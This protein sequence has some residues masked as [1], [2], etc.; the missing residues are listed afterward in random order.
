MT[1]GYTVKREGVINKGLLLG[2]LFI[3]YGWVALAQTTTFSGIGNWSD[4]A[5]WDNGVPDISYDVIIASGA[6]CTLD[7][8]AFAR[9]LSFAP[10]SI[11]STITISGT[12]TLTIESELA[13]SA[14]SGSAD[15]VLAV[16]DGALIVGSVFMPNSGSNNRNLMLTVNDGSV[17]V[18]GDV[19]MQGSSSRNYITFT[20]AGEMNVNGDFGKSDL[21]RLTGSNG[22]IR[23][24]GDFFVQTFTTNNSTIEF[25]GNGSQ[26]IRG[27]DYFNLTING[28][29]EKYLSAHSRILANL[30]LQNGLLDLA[31]RTLRIDNTASITGVFSHTSMIDFSNGGRLHK[32]G[33]N[34]SHWSGTYPIGTGTSYSPLVITS[35]SATNTN[36]Y[37]E[38]F[39]QRH[40]LLN[41]NDNA[42]ERYWLLTPP[43]AALTISGYFRYS[44]T[45]VEPPID[46]AKLIKVG[47]LNADGWQ[48]NEPGTAHDH[49]ANEISFNDIPAR[50]AWTLGEDTGCFDLVLPDKFT[51]ANGNWS[52]A[53]IWNNGTVPQNGDNVTILHAVTNNVVDGVYPHNLTITESGSLNLSNRNI[54]VSGTTD[55]YGRITDNDHAGSNTFLGFVTIHEGG[56]IT[57]GN[58]SPFVFNGGMVN[59]GL[60]SITGAGAFT[61]GNDITNN[62]PF[63]KTGT[64]AVTFSGNDMEISGTEEIVMNGAVTVSGIS[65]LNNG[66]IIFTNTVAM[67]G[68]GSW[69]QGEGASLTVGGTSVDINNFSAEA[70]D[71]TVIY[72]STAN[73]TIN[74]S[75]DYYNL[76]IQERSTK[77]LSGELNIINDFVISN[78]TNN[79]LRVIGGIND[80][81][82]G[83]DFI[84]S[85]DNNNARLDQTTG[86]F[87]ASNIS[88][89]GDRAFTFISNSITTG[90]F[91]I[92]GNNTYTITAAEI[93]TDNL[94]VKGEGTTNFSS[95]ANISNNLEIENS[96]TFNIGSTAG[97]YQFNIGNDIITGTGSTLGVIVNGLHTITV[98]KNVFVNGVFDLFVNT[99]RN[100]SLVFNSDIP[101]TIGGSP[102][103]FRVFDLRLNPGSNTTTANIDMIIAG[104]VEIG[105]GATLNAGSHTHTV[106]M[107]WN[108]EGLLV[109]SGTFIFNG[110]T[111]TLNPEPNF[112]NVSF[113]TAGS[114]FLAGNMGIAGNLEIT[115]ATVLLSN[116]DT[117]KVHHIGGDVTIH[118]GALETNNVNVIH[119][120]SIGGN[121]NVDGRLRLFFN[122]DRY[123]SLRFTDDV[124]RQIGG[125]PTQFD[126]FNI[127]LAN[128]SNSTTLVLD[129]SAA[130][131]FFLRNGIGIGNN[132]TLLTNGHDIDLYDD[133]QI[134]AGGTM[135]VNDNSALTFRASGKSI[136]NAGNLIIQGSAGNEAVVTASNSANQFFINNTTGSSLVMQHY[137]VD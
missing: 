27:G 137:F 50:G 121:L 32:Y 84:V 5:K 51:V 60:F 73:Q 131:G 68:S 53:A 119:D 104:S 20:G 47:R 61:F 9:S 69:I 76:I 112:N 22:V 89:L 25:N 6:D 34:E 100:A 94:N 101:H 7:M 115:D 106:A 128:S 113:S 90:D 127:E 110:G 91:E 38:V 56:Q 18:S 99:S 88:I 114:K 24:G 70:D 79:N 135:H 16:N 87:Q 1:K 95:N 96:S 11:N 2:F 23:I 30:E 134:A 117:S 57:S 36:M 10:E 4:D 126:I 14:P 63:S 52:S 122:N 29:G 43:N 74:T 80:I 45:D 49:S 67:T 108:N 64:G 132:A 125:S 120:L 31:G 54:T 93:F 46:E 28:I 75:S 133:V 58:N 35:S 62:G 72:S 82:V 107:N 33:S 39:D 13:Y 8:D 71:N 15:Q 77:T 44:D 111:Q 118:S 83:G 40:P 92:D 78:S 21:G 19:V 109:S 129:L 123:A 116:D 48:Q 86:N 41:G 17:T 124:S 66:S 26:R 37:I 97:T 3:F 98:N 105:A 81:N 12:N 136:Q 59:E 103:S 102:V 55:V 85:N 42:L 65:V 130:S